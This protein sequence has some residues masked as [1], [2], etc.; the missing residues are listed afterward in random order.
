[1]NNGGLIHETMDSLAYLLYL[2]NWGKSFSKWVA[3]KEYGKYSEY[4]WGIP[5]PDL[6]QID[7]KDGVEILWFLNEYKDNNICV[8][9]K[10]GEEVRVYFY[11]DIAP[12]GFWHFRFKLSEIL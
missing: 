7:E 10:A 3:P 12:E 1:M 4:E 8:S 2:K 9:I 6:I 11:D 5:K